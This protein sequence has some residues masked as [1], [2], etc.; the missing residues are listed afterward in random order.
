MSGIQQ[1]SDGAQGGGW[2][3]TG[4]PDRLVLDERPVLVASHTVQYQHPRPVRRRGGTPFGGVMAS[5]P[6]RHREASLAWIQRPTSSASDSP[7]GPATPPSRIPTDRSRWWRLGSPEVR[8]H[9][10]PPSRPGSKSTLRPVHPRLRAASG[11]TDGDFDGGSESSRR[12]S[13][14]AGRS[15]S[16]TRTCLRS[17]HRFLPSSQVGSCIARSRGCRS[18]R[19]WRAEF[20]RADPDGKSRSSV[21]PSVTTAR[22]GS[23]HGASSTPQGFPRCDQS[24]CCLSVLRRRRRT[25]T[26]SP[27]SIPPPPPPPER[28]PG[29]GVSTLRRRR[30]L[31]HPRPVPRPR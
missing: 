29:G 8:L 7:D 23:D 21:V 31:H 14:P 24:D 15:R 25:S 28:R 13:S 9:C 1:V 12:T 17:Q 18:E 26:A 16:V 4:P 20:R 11:H 3:E 10:R 30:R 2:W 27:S 19:R 6:W 5:R 22:P